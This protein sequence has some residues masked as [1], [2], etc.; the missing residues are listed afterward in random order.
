MSGVT[1]LA[2]MNHAKIADLMWKEALLGGPDDIECDDPG[3]LVLWA[4][5]ARYMLASCHLL[6]LH[7]QNQVACEIV[8]LEVRNGSGPWDL[9][10]AAVT[11][12]SPEALTAALAG[13]GKGMDIPVIDAIG[14]GTFDDRID[15]YGGFDEYRVVH[16]DGVHA[17]YLNPIRERPDA[18]VSCDPVVRLPGLALALGARFDLAAALD[19]IVEDLD[20]GTADKIVRLP[21]LRQWLSADR[22]MVV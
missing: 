21:E 13:P 2:D 9:R 14:G 6:A 3:I 17:T 4:D 10:H 8:V 18:L 12:L 7:L 20:A 5:I 1:I 19:L 22:A 16:A 15:L 11:T